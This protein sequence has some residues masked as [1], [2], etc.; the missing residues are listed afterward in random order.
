[1]C[2]FRPTD[3]SDV[4]SRIGLWNKSGGE[5]YVNVIGKNFDQR[6]QITFAFPIDIDYLTQ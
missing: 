5:N 1:M 2:H 4:R 6:L 3:I